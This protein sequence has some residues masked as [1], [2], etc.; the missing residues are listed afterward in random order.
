MREAVDDIVHFGSQC[1]TGGGGCMSSPYD[2]Y[3]NVYQCALLNRNVLYIVDV[4]NFE[5]GAEYVTCADIPFV[6]FV[7]DTDDVLVVQYLRTLRAHL[8]TDAQDL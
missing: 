3:G 7:V 8:L 1:G 2:G 5:T 6:Y 4:R